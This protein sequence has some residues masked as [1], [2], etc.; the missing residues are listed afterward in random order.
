MFTLVSCPACGGD[1]AESDVRCRACGFEEAAEDVVASWVADAR[2]GPA[3]PGGDE[4]VCLAC[5]YAG[6]LVEAPDGGRALCPA[7]GTPW[8]DAGGILRKVSCPDCG[9]AILLTEQ[10]RE[11]TVICPGCHALLGC[12]VGRERRGAG[13]R[14]GLGAGG[15]TTLFDLM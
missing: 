2:D 14:K 5:G 11:K 8:Q 15:N 10:H 12:L 7:C 1:W 4:A 9:Q 13:R 3:P 6:P